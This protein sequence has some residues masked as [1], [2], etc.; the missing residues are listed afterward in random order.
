LERG[1]L[2]VLCA[3][4]VAVSLGA[5]LR[6]RWEIVPGSSQ[7]AVFDTWRH[8]FCDRQGCTAAVERL[9]QHP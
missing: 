2:V 3:C 6:V 1:V 8:A 4:M 9:P 5:V 7:G